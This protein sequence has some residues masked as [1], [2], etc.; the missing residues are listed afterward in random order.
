[1]KDLLNTLKKEI[2]G[3]EEGEEIQTKGVD[4]LFN[5][6]IGENF[7]NYRKGRES[8]YMRISEH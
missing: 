7:S 2:I 4:K 1:M 3:T 6:V 5:N 8:R